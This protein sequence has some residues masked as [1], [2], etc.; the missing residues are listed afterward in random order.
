MKSTTCP[1]CGAYGKSVDQQYVTVTSY[2]CGAENDG[3]RFLCESIYVSAGDAYYIH[4]STRCRDRQE[5]RAELLAWNTGEP[6]EHVRVV[7]YKQED[8][9]ENVFLA[10]REGELWSWLDVDVHPESA[11]PFDVRIGIKSGPWPANFDKWREVQ[12]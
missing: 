9:N 8:S 1:K 3:D 2:E 6:P 10:Q 11:D 5:A 4:Q 7:L 12:P